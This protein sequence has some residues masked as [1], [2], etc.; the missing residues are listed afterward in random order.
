MSEEMIRKEKLEKMEE[1]FKRK[2]RMSENW[3]SEKKSIVYKD[4][5]GFEIEDVED[6]EKKNEE[7]ENDI[8]EYEESVKDV[9]EVYKEMEEEKYNEI[10]RINERK[11]NVMS[12]WK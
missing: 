8:F 4:K 9:V 6:D 11:E 2:E 12:M 3:M 10:E 1:R 5:F 7:I